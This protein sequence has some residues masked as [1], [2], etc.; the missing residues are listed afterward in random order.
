LALR[1]L[2]KLL[3][4]LEKNVLA[5]THGVVR[6]VGAAAATVAAAAERDLYLNTRAGVCRTS[7]CLSVIKAGL[8]PVAK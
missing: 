3:T 6:A 4:T 1:K 7:R 5:R 2:S 8:T